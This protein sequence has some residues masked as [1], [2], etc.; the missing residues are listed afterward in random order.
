MVHIKQGA[1]GP[2]EQQVAALQMGL[3]QLRGHIGHHRQNLLS[4]QGAL[5]EHLLKVN[6]WCV[7][8]LGQHKIV[9]VQVFA[10]FVGKALG[11]LEVLNAQGSAGNFV[12]VSRANATTGGANFVQAGFF[13]GGFTGHIDGGVVG[14]YQGT[15]FADAQARAHRHA[16]R[17]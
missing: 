5:V 12:F 8:V 7:E 15:G 1:L 17:L 13:F 3:V 4:F 2:F 11:V 9:Q 16:S 6:R 14:Q 10:Q